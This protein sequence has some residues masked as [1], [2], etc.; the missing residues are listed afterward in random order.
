MLTKQAVGQSQ[1]QRLNI[2][3]RRMQPVSPLLM[4]L[5]RDEGAPALAFLAE[6]YGLHRI[7]GL[8]TKQAIVNR[9]LRTLTQQQLEQ[10]KD[11]LIAA[12][13]GALSVDGLVRLALVQD[14]QRAGRPAPRLDQ[15]SPDSATLV[16]RSTGRWIY[17][18]RGHDVLVDIG[19]H[20]L[21]C[22]CGYFRFSARRSALCKHLA[23]VFRLI[24]E[25]YAREGLI[26]L[27]VSREYGGPNTPQWRFSPLR[28]QHS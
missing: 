17:T 9:V 7:P 22:D 13:F 11:D 21:A 10:I 19:Q 2:P 28:K 24:P 18:M 26:D 27:L 5:L 16:E 25:A 12:R 3:H 1:Q 15:I 6:R 8:T 23:T 20:L 14:K 4:N